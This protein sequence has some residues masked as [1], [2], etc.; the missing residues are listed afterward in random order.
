MFCL[1][2]FSRRRKANRQGAHRDTLA[3]LRNETGPLGAARRKVFEKRNRAGNVDPEN[4]ARWVDA[5]VS[6]IEGR[7]LAE[8]LGFWA[9]GIPSVVGA[10][11]ARENLFSTF[12]AGFAQSMPAPGIVTAG[13]SGVVK[14]DGLTQSNCGARRRVVQRD[15]LDSPMR[16]LKFE[17]IEAFFSISESLQGALADGARDGL[18]IGF[19]EAI[20]ALV[21]A[22]RNSVLANDLA[23]VK[24]AG[25]DF[26][27]LVAALA[28]LSASPDNSDVQRAAEVHGAALRCRVLVEAQVRAANNKAAADRAS[29]ELKLA[30]A[31]A[32]TKGAKG[33][34]KYVLRRKDLQAIPGAGRAEIVGVVNDKTG[35]VIL[36][37]HYCYAEDG[38]I[39]RRSKPTATA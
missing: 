30:K 39:K 31:I 14:G 21:A 10:N 1:D 12:L 4:G 13:P 38:T 20:V 11:G 7:S 15:A 26:G 25:K 34:Q 37:P 16:R 35:E 2:E 33:D 32:R 27:A 5:L 24:Q 8:I 36:G 23:A 3:A 9:D 18:P 17:D 28:K 22:T 29:R 19:S 6:F